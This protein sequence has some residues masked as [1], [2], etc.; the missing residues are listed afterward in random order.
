MNSARSY[1]TVT[2][3]KNQLYVMGGINAG[4]TFSSVEH[5][6][7][8]SSH[9]TYRADMLVERKAHAMGVL[10]GKIYVLGGMDK[11]HHILNS[12]ESYQPETDRWSDVTSMRKHRCYYGAAVLKNRIYAVGG[13]TDKEKFI[14]ASVECYD[15]LLDRWIDVAPMNQRRCGQIYAVGGSNAKERTLA[16]VECYDPLKNRWT[17]L[18]SMNRER[19]DV[20]VTV[21]QGQLCAVGG[22]HTLGIESSVE[23][24]DAVN[25]QWSFTHKRMIRSRY[26]HGVA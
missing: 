25:N 12:V 15:F 22:R 24:Y 8:V 16:T 9:W 10:N 14:T 13:R 23:V 5:Y 20:A 2:R 18:A 19:D 7:P 4:V 26:A 3:W 11:H 17:V 6:D 21:F 1:H